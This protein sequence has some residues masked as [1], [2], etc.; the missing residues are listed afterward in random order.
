MGAQGRFCSE[1]GKPLPQLRS[2]QQSSSPRAFVI[3]ISTMISKAASV[4]AGMLIAHLSPMDSSLLL[5]LRGH[6]GVRI[7]QEV[8]SKKQCKWLRARQ[9]AQNV[10][11]IRL[12]HAPAHRLRARERMQPCSAT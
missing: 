5:M 3:D 11:T 9:M 7:M 12:S 4:I 1:R 10:L 8:T 2:V 6:G